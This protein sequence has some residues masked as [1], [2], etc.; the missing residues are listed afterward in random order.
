M[1]GLWLFIEEIWQFIK[2]NAAA[3]GAAAA[4]VAVLIGVATGLFRAVFMAGVGLIK[5]FKRKKEKTS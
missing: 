5:L 4:A 2:D 3:V 1:A